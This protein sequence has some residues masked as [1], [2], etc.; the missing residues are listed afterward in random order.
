MKPI[1]SRDSLGKTL[2][3][4]NSDQ[5]YK[6]FCDSKTLRIAIQ[7]KGRLKAESVKF[8]KS[9]GINITDTER[10]LIGKCA[11]KNAEILYVRHGDIPRYVENGVAD[12]GIVGENVIYEKKFSIKKIRALGF[13]KCTLVIAVPKNS[14]IKTISDLEGERIA[15]SYPNSLKKFLKENKINASII[16][17]QGSVEIAPLLGLADAICDITQTGKTLDENGLKRIIDVF[18][19][20]ALL[21][22]NV[23]TSK[24]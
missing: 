12:F 15:T 24:L 11:D 6:P 1:N 21:I 5:Y 8:L 17:I 19:S 23:L 9:F 13:G 3:S 4:R 7:N 16:E 22:G 14:K 10:G 20:K 18:E 2:S